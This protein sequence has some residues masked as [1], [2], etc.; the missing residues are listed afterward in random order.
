MFVQDVGIVY[1]APVRDSDFLHGGRQENLAVADALLIDTITIPGTGFRRKSSDCFSKDSL[2]ARIGEVT[3][4]VVL[5]SQIVFTTDLNKVFSYPNTYPMPAIDMPEPV[6]LTTFTHFPSVNKPLHILDLQGSFRDF[7]VFTA[8]NQILTANRELLDYFHDMQNSEE[9]SQPLFPCPTLLETPPQ[10]PRIIS[11]AF[12]DHH[13]HALHEDGTLTSWGS[14]SQNCGALGLGDKGAQEVRGILDNHAGNAHLPR[15]R[16]KTVWFE[17]LME[18][19]L[20]DVYRKA[21]E[22]ELLD[23]LDTFGEYYEKEGA[24][25]EADIVS[26]NGELGAYFVLKVAAGGWSSAAL[27]LVDEEKAEQAREAHIIRPD[28]P[29]SESDSGA[30]YEYGDS[31]FDMVEIALSSIVGWI[32]S[33][34]RWFLGLTERDARR[35]AAIAAQSAGAFDEENRV[36]YSWSENPVPVEEIMAM[37]DVT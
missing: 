19:W 20:S 14:E 24:R 5:E 34:G 15:H 31:P 18:C 35:A 17:P 27:V 33:T 29:P 13:T 22:M 4:Y 11:L 3:N 6:E 21:E 2:E 9:I 16:A 8:S 36:K 7:A 25:W 10:R 37:R 1:W 30:E 23:G 26:E 28:V 32:R 12:G